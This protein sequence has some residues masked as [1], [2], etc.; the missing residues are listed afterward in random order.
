MY[1]KNP[2]IVI[3]GAGRIAFSLLNSLMK[4][5]FSVQSVF[6]KNIVSAEKLAKKYSINHYSNN[7]SKVKNDSNLFL[8]TV[9]DNQIVSVANDFGKLNINFQN[10]LFVH[11]SGSLSSSALG[12]LKS[13]GADTASFHIMQSFPTK[14]FVP[15]ENITA[16]IETDS[17]KVEKFLFNI[18]KKLEMI[19]FKLYKDDKVN[20]HLAGV[21]S[22]NFF[23]GNLL[24]AEK[25]LQNNKTEFP[26]F[27]KLILP[28]AS[29]TLNNIKSKGLKKSLSGPIQRGELEVIKNHIEKIKNMGNEKFNI[30]GKNIFLLNYICQSITI[31]MMLEKN[32]IILNE[33]QKTV[34]KFLGDEFQNLINN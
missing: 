25:V 8:L 11:F 7:L 14:D 2:K 21:Y 16:A 22:S 4:A 15:L 10:S 34:Y 19:P 9:P 6:S 1:N 3:V 5:R 24:G 20:Y 28:I 33:N 18:A 27:E 32:G 13:R 26:D 17:D 23:V 31:L 30:N 29:T 12:S